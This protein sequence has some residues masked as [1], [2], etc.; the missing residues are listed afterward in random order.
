MYMYLFYLQGQLFLIIPGSIIKAGAFLFTIS[1]LF[2]FI[3]K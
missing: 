1:G 3:V 2:P